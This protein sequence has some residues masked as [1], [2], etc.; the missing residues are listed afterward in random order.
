MFD[1]LKKKGRNRVGKLLSLDR[2]IFP[3]FHSF[4]FNLI[5]YPCVRTKR[6]DDNEQIEFIPFLP[7]VCS[8]CLESAY[9][10]CPLV[11]WLIG[12]VVPSKYFPVHFILLLMIDNKRSV[13]R[14]RLVSILR[15]LKLSSLFISLQILFQTFHMGY[16][17]KV[18]YR[19]QTKNMPL[20]ELFH[21][22]KQRVS[23]V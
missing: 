9:C 16:G 19:K 22:G 7:A 11:H 18:Y 8:F 17:I 3:Y 20:Q 5:F 4:Y 1:S 21:C 10:P 15:C 6:T 12:P 2:A 13:G 23:D 14:C